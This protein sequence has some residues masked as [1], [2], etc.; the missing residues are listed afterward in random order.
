MRPSERWSMLLL[1]LF[2]LSAVFLWAA[3][4]A[5][6]GRS[7]SRDPFEGAEIF[8]DYCAS[9]HGATGSGHGPASVALRHAVPDLTRISQRNGGVFPFQRV[10]EIIEGKDP[11]PLAHGNREMPIW[12]P[13]FHEV[14]SDQDLGEIR[15]D[16]I[17]KHVE[18][19][20][21]K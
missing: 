16:A 5:N 6:Q 15:L 7:P 8:R 2:L 20:Q 11:G 4:N 19:M 18:A 17:T 14:E 9:C 13:V 10:K 21:Q 12:G 1:A 3:Q